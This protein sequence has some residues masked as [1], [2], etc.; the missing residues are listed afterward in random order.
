[1]EQ[2][3]LRR[4][5]ATGRPFTQE[6]GKGTKK[7][8]ASKDKE[9]SELLTT[10]PLSDMNRGNGRAIQRRTSRAIESHL[11][12]VGWISRQK[13]PRLP[14]EGEVFLLT[15]PFIELPISF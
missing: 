13:I 8:D 5:R 14:A 15:S 11:Q 1:M 7:E 4:A 9:Y 3:S 12:T 6:G 10:E 2:R